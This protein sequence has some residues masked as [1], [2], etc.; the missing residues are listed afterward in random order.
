MSGQHN[1]Q[2]TESLQGKDLP[3]KTSTVCFSQAGQHAMTITETR[4]ESKARFLNAALHVIRAKGHF[5]ARIEGI[6]DDAGLTKGS[7]FHHFDIKE[8]LAFDAV[9]Y[10]I[11]R[12]GI[13]FASGPYRSRTIRLTA[14]SR[15][16][17]SARRNVE[18][19]VEPD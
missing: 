2:E 15:R 12:T 7:F 10:W 5:T 9:D 6:Y 3:E 18:T 4:H 11:E 8:A 19:E 17:I 13:E 1:Y 14:C 16:L